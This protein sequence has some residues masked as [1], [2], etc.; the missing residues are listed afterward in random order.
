MIYLYIFSPLKALS[1]CIY[2]DLFVYFQSFK[3]TVS[4]KVTK[5]RGTKCWFFFVYD[6]LPFCLQ[7]L[8]KKMI[9]S[10]IRVT[11]LLSAVSVQKLFYPSLESLTCSLQ[12]LNTNILSL[13]R[14]THLLSAVTVQKSFYPFFKVSCLQ[15]FYP[16]LESLPCRLQFSTKL[17]YPSSVTHLLSV[18]IFLKIFYPYS[19]LL[20]C[21]LQLLCKKWFY[22]SIRRGILKVYR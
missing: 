22:P 14:I 4:L 20:T 18:V 3:S 6:S 5:A 8:C 13:F 10:L 9:L 15:L 17:F 2:H 21:C 1:W 11:H 16:Y 19:E 12:L 7:L